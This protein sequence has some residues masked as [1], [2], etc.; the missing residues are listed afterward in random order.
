VW[1]DHA[2]F[3]STAYAGTPALKTDF[4]RTGKRTR[5]GAFEDFTKSA[6][7]YLKNNYFDGPRQVIDFGYPLRS[8][9]PDFRMLTTCSPGTMFLGVALP[10]CCRWLLTIA[11]CSFAQSVLI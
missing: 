8:R 2:N 5:M 4:T 6:M 3:I 7:R 10:I 11:L 1:S 9:L